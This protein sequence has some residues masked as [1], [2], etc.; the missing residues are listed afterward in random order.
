MHP[1]PTKNRCLPW[2]WAEAIA[3]AAIVHTTTR[4]C[5]IIIIGIIVIGLV[6][7]STSVAY[8]G[9]R[10]ILDRASVEAQCRVASLLD[11]CHCAQR[12]ASNQR[13][14]QKAS[15]EVA[16][17]QADTI[18]RAHYNWLASQLAA[19]SHSCLSLCASVD[20]VV[21]ASK[22]QIKRI[23]QRGAQKRRNR[24]RC[25]SFDCWVAGCSL[26]AFLQTGTMTN[27]EKCL[28]G[29][30]PASAGFNGKEG[31]HHQWDLCSLDRLLLLNVTQ[32]S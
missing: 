21:N 1:S 22:L 3:A 23:A 25:L 7:V 4:C 30:T 19:R 15:K 31:P 27:H 8:S 32:Q 17:R 10:R 12:S 2:R 16:G 11:A 29:R 24:S 13:V 28:Q 20:L 26:V 14:R 5:P 6:R 9:T 18:A